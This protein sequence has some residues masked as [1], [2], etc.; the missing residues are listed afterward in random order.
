MR[1]G[2]ARIARGVRADCQRAIRAAGRFTCAAV[3]RDDAPVGLV[4]AVREGQE[5]AEQSLHALDLEGQAAAEENLLYL[6]QRRPVGVLQ[7]H[8]QHS[9]QQHR[10]EQALEL[11]QQVVTHDLADVGLELPQRQRMHFELDVRLDAGGEAA[12]VEGVAGLSAAE[13]GLEV[14]RDLPRAGGEEHALKH[15]LLLQLVHRRQH[16]M[17]ERALLLECSQALGR[18]V[19]AVHGEEDE[20]EPVADSHKLAD[21]LPLLLVQPV[22]DQQDFLSRGQRTKTL[23]VAHRGRRCQPRRLRHPVPEDLLRR[24]EDQL[25]AGGPD[26]CP[27]RR[28]QPSTSTRARPWSYARPEQER[29]DPMQRRREWRRK[30]MENKWERRERERRYKRRGEYHLE[31]VDHLE[32][33]LLQRSE[34]L[35][36]HLGEN[37]RVALQDDLGCRAVVM[38]PELALAPDVELAQHVSQHLRSL[39]TISGQRKVHGSDDAEGGALQLARPLFLVLLSLGAALQGAALEDV[40]ELGDE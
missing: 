10:P 30:A 2:F 18:R 3:E 7:D 27:A 15:H 19:L 38:L 17:R 28:V 4:E 37:L 31:E 13:D 35:L 22:E 23:R 12:Q 16:D 29:Q 39:R 20:E 32:A 1:G 6:L 40:N 26:T 8:L 33:F 11:S 34:V 25:L 24:D 21:H 9:L 5:R 36:H 14:L